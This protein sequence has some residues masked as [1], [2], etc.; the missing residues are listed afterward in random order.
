[1]TRHTGASVLAGLCVFALCGRAYAQTTPPKVP[2]NLEPG[3]IHQQN[4]KTR[5][6]F[7]QQQKQREADKVT[8]PVIRA[9]QSPVAQTGNAAL[10]F[11]LKQVRFS[12]S[13]FLSQQELQSIAAPYIGKRVTFAVL[14]QIVDAINKL[15]R[16]QGVVT[17]QA[18]LPPQTIH[19]GSIEITLVEGRLGHVRVED[20]VHTKTHF[21]RSRIPIQAR[22]RVDIDLLRQAL[23]Y[24]NRTND[25]QLQALLKP[26]TSLGLTDIVLKADEPP[27]MSGDVFVDNA[28]VD[29]TSK[30]RLGATFTYNNLFGIDDTFNMYVAHSRGDTDGSI[31]YDVPVN[32]RN[33]RIGFSYARATTRIINGPFSKLDL[34]GHSYTATLRM[35]QPLMATQR[36]L[37]MIDGALSRIDSTSDAA[38]VNISNSRINELKA[39]FS[40]TYFGD[41]QRLTT[42]H[43]L[44]EAR[45]DQTLDGND[46]FF[47]YNGSISDLGRF[48]KYWAYQL[49]LSGQ[50]SSNKRLPPSLLFQL[51]GLGSVRGYERGVLAGPSGYIASVAIHRY[52][53]QRWDLYGFIDRGQ[54]FA[55]FPNSDHLNSAGLGAYWRP[56]QWISAS[57][58]VARPFD[59]VTSYQSGTRVDFR[60]TFHWDAD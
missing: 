47:I 34:T 22:Q 23:I 58:D 27:R 45:S 6:Y 42:S 36:W 20:N 57:L 26:G 40:A 4:Q 38:G 12:K 13:D 35:T 9:G 56:R 2:P 17:A 1:M 30:N 41:R 18:V 8:Q 24:F 51:G 39:S 43:I 10:S 21:I 31:N 32:K 11:V 59:T 37:L 48:G 53:G 16:S 44:T 15:Y 25:I 60:I 52:F 28:G 7:N 3:A 54:V 49:S 46:Q 5:D 14:Q 29:S 55:S 50:W 19:N 33:G